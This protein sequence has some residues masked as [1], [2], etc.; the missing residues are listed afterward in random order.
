MRFRRLLPFVLLLV[1]GSVISASAAGFLLPPTYPD[2]VGGYAVASG[3]F[4]GDGNID[5]AVSGINSPNYEVVILLNKG[6]G[7]FQPAVKYNAGSN[8]QG[9]TVG[10]LNN[11]GFLDIAAADVSPGSDAVSVLLGNGDGTFGT[12]VNYPLGTSVAKLAGIRMGDFNGDHLPDVVINV[13]SGLVVLL[14]TGAS[15]KPQH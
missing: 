9:V 15:E 2:G 3:D 10:D 7:T 5:Y 6:D 14:N 13:S 11:D 4:N 8:P 12:A 1:V